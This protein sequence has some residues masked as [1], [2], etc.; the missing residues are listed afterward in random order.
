[1]GNTKDVEER[2]EDRQSGNAASKAAHAPELD[3]RLYEPYVT[4]RWF[5]ETLR[6]IGIIFILPLIARIRVRGRH[7]IPRRGPYIIASN[8]LSWT[9]IPL[10]PF[11][12]PD[13]VTYMAKRELFVGRLG[14]L[15][16]LLG[17]FPVKRGEADRQ[18]MR[19]AS[20]QL[21]KGKIFVIFPEGTR[22][23]TRTMNKAHAGLGMI[24]LRSEVPVL[25]V[26]IWGSEHI[27]KKFRPEV[28][29]VYGEPVTFRPQGTKLT[30]EEIDRTTD[31]IM[32]RIAAMLPEQYRGVYGV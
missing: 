4:P 22:S 1:A 17:A 24:A 3:K 14:W 2:K 8:H 32:H 20:E 29:I 16:R 31:E 15:V 18:A 7:N 9:D 5:W 10:I 11:W 6:I 12:I 23:K 26:A 21:K 19:A 30:R 25:P 28:T 27:F 13:R